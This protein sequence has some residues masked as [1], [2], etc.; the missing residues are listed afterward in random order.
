MRSGITQKSFAVLVGALLVSAAAW[1]QSPPLSAPPAPLNLQLPP[2]AVEPPPGYKAPP[3][4]LEKVRGYAAIYVGHREASIPFSYMDDEGKIYGYSWE[5]C[6]RIVD[7]IKAR[8]ELPNLTVVPVLTT[9]STRMMM[10]ETGTVDLQCGSET[11]T[12]QRARYVAFSNT[13]FV[14]GV[15][16]MVRKSSGIKTIKDLSGKVVVTT[17]GTTN[18]VAAKTAA[19][20]RNIFVNFRSGRTHLDSFQ[21]VLDGKADVFVLDDILLHGLLAAANQ[22]DA[23]KLVLLEEAMAFEPYGLMFRKGDAE[24]KKLVDETLVGLMKSGEFERIYAKWFQSPI[25]PKGI[26][27]NVPMSAELKQLIKTPNDRG[28]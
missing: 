13:F 26:N 6:M 25:P 23:Y 12:E 20:R 22:S 4:T 14:T 11:N 16:G 3:T 19:A 2:A 8:L 7:V 28:I 9:P 24:M 5:L 10:V 21:Q 15:K 27:L 1:A 18:D 17:A